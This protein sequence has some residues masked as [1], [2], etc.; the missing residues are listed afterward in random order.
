MSSDSH[1]LEGT[2]G[3]TAATGGQGASHASP[4]TS[5]SEDIQ[6]SKAAAADTAFPTGIVLAIAGLIVVLVTVIAVVVRQRLAGNDRD[7]R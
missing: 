7:K 1:P 5:D 4:G 3:F 2:F 6:E